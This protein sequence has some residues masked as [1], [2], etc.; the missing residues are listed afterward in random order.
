[1]PAVV[2]H[3]DSASIVSWRFAGK[4]MVLLCGVGCG[5]RLGPWPGHN[6]AQKGKRGKKMG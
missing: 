3:R 1:M 4:Q 2:K 5:G 6:H